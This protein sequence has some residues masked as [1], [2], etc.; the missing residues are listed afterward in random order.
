MSLIKTNNTSKIL[1]L[2]W[3]IG[4]F[5]LITIFNNSILA[6]LLNPSFNAID[7]LVQ[8]NNHKKSITTI[9]WKDSFVYKNLVKNIL[10]RE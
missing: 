2:H 5:F 4:G 10:E 3:I 1:N 6:T 9:I 8:L 7:N